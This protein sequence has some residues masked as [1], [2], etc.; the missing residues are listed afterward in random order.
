M[1]QDL[2]FAPVLR[3]FLSLPLLSRYVQAI[4]RRSSN[5]G[6]VDNVHLGEAS[7]ATFTNSDF[8]MLW[9]HAPTGTRNIESHRALCWPIGCF[10]P[11]YACA[12]A[13]EGHS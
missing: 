13:T 7:I 5:A 11:G 3:L 6:L 10:A 2:R 8:R 1:R 12:L 9:S 4:D